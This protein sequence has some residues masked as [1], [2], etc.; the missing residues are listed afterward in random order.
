MIHQASTTLISGL[1]GSA[2]KNI[3]GGSE[4]IKEYVNIPYYDRY[5]S[6]SPKT[7]GTQLKF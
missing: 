2:H 3:R 5:S 7:I 4:C 1:N 6:S